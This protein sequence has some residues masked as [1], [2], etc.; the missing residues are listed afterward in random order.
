M[1]NPLS[2]SLSLPPPTP[3][4]IQAPTALHTPRQGRTKASPPP[5]ERGA[6]EQLGKPGVKGGANPHAS[7]LAV[8]AT[9][10]QQAHSASICWLLAD[11][12]GCCWHL[13]ESHRRVRSHGT[14]NIH[15]HP[16]AST[17]IHQH[18]PASTSICQHHADSASCWWTPPL[19]K[20]LERE[21]LLS[22]HGSLPLLPQPPP[23]LHTC[24]GDMQAR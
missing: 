8:L 15:Q 4:P 10:A 6:Q 23:C 21:E 1:S 7:T 5:N 16:P 13:P 2:L 19:V 22:S 11:S 20:R 24:I 17:S 18:P 12:T 9:H 14:S 3:H